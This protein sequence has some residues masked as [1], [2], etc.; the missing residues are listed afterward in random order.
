MLSLSSEPGLIVQI[1][2][3]VTRQIT[4]SK[5]AYSSTSADIVEEGHIFIQNSL[6][7]S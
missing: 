4:L 6:E 2:E 5:R 7:Y 1:A 3:I